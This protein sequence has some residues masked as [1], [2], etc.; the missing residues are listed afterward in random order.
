MSTILL[1]EDNPDD[2]MLALRALKKAAGK[3]DVVVM[4]DGQE[5]VDWVFGQG[6]FS[7]R[8]TRELPQVIFLDIRLPKLS[9]LQVLETIRQNEDT[10][11]IPVVLMTS[12]NEELD[13]VNGYALGA[14]SYINKPGSF[15]DF[16]DQ[17]RVLGHYWLGINRT[18][19]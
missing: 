6:K 10:K 3:T 15:D 8:N 5:A 18:P 12:S 16:I 17:V 19:H 4:R 11:L 1:V 13:L 7:G 9:G 14:N 2:E